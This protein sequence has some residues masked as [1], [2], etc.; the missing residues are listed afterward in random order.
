MDSWWRERAVEGRSGGGKERWRG[1]GKEI[2]RIILWVGN[3][4]GSVHCMCDIVSGL[5]LVVF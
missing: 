1:G 5:D 2:C 3:S 4:C